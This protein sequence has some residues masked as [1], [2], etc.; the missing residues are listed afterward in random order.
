MSERRTCSVIDTD[1]KSMRYRSPRDDDAKLRKKLR[2]LTNQRRRFGYR[3]QHILLRRDGVLINRKKTP[4]IYQK[5]GLAVRRRDVLPWNLAVLVGSN[6]K[7]TDDNEA[8]QV[9]RKADYRGIEGAGGWDADGGGLPPLQHQLRFV[10]QA[11]V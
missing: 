6:A 3:R 5:E 8:E 1:H 9:Q 2:E 10:L 7:K 4:R 11:T